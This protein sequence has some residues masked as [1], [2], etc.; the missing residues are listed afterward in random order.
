MAGTVEESWLGIV[1]LAH[2]HFFANGL[3]KSPV[4]IIALTEFQIV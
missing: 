3:D 1:A 4:F 2:F